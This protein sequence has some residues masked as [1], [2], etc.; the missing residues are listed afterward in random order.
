MG[1]VIKVIDLVNMKVNKEKMPKH[2]IINKHEYFYNE[3]RKTYDSEYGER[4]S[5]DFTDME[6]E[7]LDE[8]DEIDIQKIN[9]EDLIIM[10]QTRTGEN[11][12]YSISIINKKIMNSINNLIDEVKQLDNKINKLESED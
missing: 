12:S 7:I 6:V 5:F 11:Y 8:E 1:K 4:M 10:P 3:N 9:E 2:I